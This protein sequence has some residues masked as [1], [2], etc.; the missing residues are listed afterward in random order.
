MLSKTG[1]RRLLE[2]VDAPLPS[3]FRELG[4]ISDISEK[5]L[6]Q[7]TVIKPAQGSNNRG[8]LP[9]KPIAPGLWREVETGAD[10]T[11][12]RIHELLARALV[13]HSLT[14]HWVGE[15]LLRAPD[16]G[17][18]A[19]TKLL[20][21]RGQLGAAFVRRN[22]ERTF[23]WF[24][25]RWK[26]IA[27]GIRRHSPD[28]SLTPPEDRVRLTEL[29]ARISRAL[30]IPFVRVDLYSTAAGPVVG[31]LT[32]F[33]GWAHDLEDVLDVRLGTLYER[34]ET[35]LLANGMDWTRLTDAPGVTELI[36]E[37]APAKRH[38]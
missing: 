22:P 20:M 17:T 28:S 25:E 24:D 23:T 18:V 31:E 9:L 2:A 35:A 36:T 29:A 6:A 32:P 13:Q 38:R 3:E 34:T 12:P 15:E 5:S 26:P 21:F 16:G 30:P 10:L 7:P 4:T 37:F 8:V 1:T 14:D 33:P 27:S 11:L 19:D